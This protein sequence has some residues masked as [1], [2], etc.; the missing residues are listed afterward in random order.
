MFIQVFILSPDNG[1][2]NIGA[3]VGAVVGGVVAVITCTCLLEVV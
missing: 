3:V 2:I 1:G